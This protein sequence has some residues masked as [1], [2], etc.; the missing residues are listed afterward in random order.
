VS[1]HFIN[2]CQSVIRE[3]EVSFI[4]SNNILTRIGIN[5]IRFE[6]KHVSGKRKRSFKKRRRKYGPILDRCIEGGHNIVEVEVEGRGSNYMRSQLIKLVEERRL[7]DRVKASVVNGVL[8][9]EK[10]ESH[11]LVLDRTLTYSRR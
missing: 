3:H 7:E 11:N 2:I 4:S 1:S 6:L 8:Y 5:E 9:L 10:V